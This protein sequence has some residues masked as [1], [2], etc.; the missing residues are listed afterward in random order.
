MAEDLYQYMEEKQD[1]NLDHL[2]YSVLA[3]GDSDY[4]NFVGPGKILIA[5]WKSCT[6]KIAGRVD[7]DDH[8][9][10]NFDYWLQDVLP[11]IEDEAKLQLLN[12]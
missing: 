4:D 2:R 6:Q 8:Y 11:A 9:W 12:A 1:A 5:C 7:C 3:L 10:H